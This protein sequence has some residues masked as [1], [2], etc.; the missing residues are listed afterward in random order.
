MRNRW[1]GVRSER[2]SIHALHEESDI[3]SVV[4]IAPAFGDFNPRSP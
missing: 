4:N 2:I 3:K 1:R